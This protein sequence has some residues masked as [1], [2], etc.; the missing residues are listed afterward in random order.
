[1]KKDDYIHARISSDLKKAAQQ[2][3]KDTGRTLAGLIEWLLRKELRENGI[4]DRQERNE[5]MKTLEEWMEEMM[6]EVEGTVE[7]SCVMDEVPHHPGTKRFEVYN[8]EGTFRKLYDITL[9]EE[10]NITNIE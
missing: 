2:H 1:M 8:E 5:T 4:A 9:D 7:I 6:E 10:Q 3:A